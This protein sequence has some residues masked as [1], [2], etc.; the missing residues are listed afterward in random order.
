MNC[1]L[2]KVGLLAASFFFLTLQ[3]QVNEQ[4]I[5]PHDG[6]LFGLYGQAASVSGDLLVVGG[7]PGFLKFASV[8]VYN[9][10]PNGWA[11]QAKITPS[12]SATYGQAFGKSVA[13][14]NNRLIVGAPVDAEMV[15]NSGAAYVY[16]QDQGSGDW[17][18]ASKL[19]ANDPGGGDDYG[20]TVD[21]HGDFA[22]VG[23]P[24]NNIGTNLDQGSAY[25][26]EREDGTGSWIF[27]Q[28][29]LASDGTAN[30]EYGWSVS[31]FGDYAAVGAWL[32]DSLEGAVYIYKRESSGWEEKQRITPSDK[33]YG[34]PF[35]SF[36]AAVSLDGDRLLVGAW[37]MDLTG[38]AYVFRRDNEQWVEEGKLVTDDSQNSDFYGWSV[39]LSGDQ[40]LVGAMAS[41]DVSDDNGSAYVFVRDGNSWMQTDK[42]ISF[43]ATSGD[44]FGYS[45][46]LDN[47]VAL[48]GAPGQEENGEAAG[49]AY[50]YDGFG[51]VGIGDLSDGIPGH[52]TLEQNYPN[53]FNPSTVIPFSIASAGEV[54]LTI[55]NQLGETVKTLVQGSRPAGNY[56]VTWRG[57]NQRGAQVASGIYFYR[58]RVDGFQQ[59]R[60]LI[61]LR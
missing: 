5:L 55:Y 48:V 10:T 11:Q 1:K 51:M 37:G 52:F 57:Y 46:G 6:A 31:I 29:L 45:V 61:Y 15:N 40:A 32:A 27:R 47:G 42:L 13:M 44:Q 34:V 14:H 58:L 54:E 26:Y 36:G 12:D 43:D 39:A 16:E 49:A 20:L 30:H 41:D 17:I 7:G 56:Q 18:F 53:P 59:T 33:Q 22:I 25:I 19:F 28:Q 35:A 50:V 23:A 4:K 3:A 24:N 21:I 9:N 60:K 38:A 8:Y 2:L